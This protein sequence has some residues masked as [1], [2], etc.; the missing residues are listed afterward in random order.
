LYVSGKFAKSVVKFN[1]ETSI[2]FFFYALLMLEVKD[3]FLIGM[4]LPLETQAQ[5]L[6]FLF[7]FLSG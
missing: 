3:V 7:G 6:K 5:S 2:F 1:S 4:A